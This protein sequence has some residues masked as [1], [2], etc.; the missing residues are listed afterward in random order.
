VRRWRRR[1]L[2]ETP[3]SQDGERISSKLRCVVAM[4]RCARGKLPMRPDLMGLRLTVE[5]GCDF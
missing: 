1:G 4:T 2:P 5:G 3:T